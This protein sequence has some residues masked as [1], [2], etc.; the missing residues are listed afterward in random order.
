[1]L[2]HLFSLFF[3]V[4]LF[5]SIFLLTLSQGSFIVS[6]I[7]ITDCDEAG[8]NGY[9]GYNGVS[10]VPGNQQQRELVIQHVSRAGRM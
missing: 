3:F 1:M 8:K 2:S 4:C 6:G 5:I 7:V 9:R 10:V